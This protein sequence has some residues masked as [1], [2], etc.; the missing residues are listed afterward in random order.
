MVN[1]I[2]E[3]SVVDLI[4]MTARALVDKPDE[5][6]VT[7]ASNE[8]STMLKLSVDSTDVAKVI[9]QHGKMA[10]SLRTLLGAISVTLKHQYSLEIVEDGNP[11]LASSDLK[12][13]GTAP[14]R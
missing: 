12:A 8:T 2:T 13:T 4:A 3:L 9:G 5:V 10:R 11:H 7:A 14:P 6:S 1:T